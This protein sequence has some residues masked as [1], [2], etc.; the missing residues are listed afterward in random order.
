M[1]RATAGSITAPSASP[2]G[3]HLMPGTT[4]GASAKAGTRRPRPSDA[5]TTTDEVGPIST[6]WRTYFL[7]A[8]AATSNVAASARA[9]GVS[10]S[11][12]YNARRD[13]AEF[14]EAWRGALHE[15]Y[16]HLEMEALAYLRGH[17]PERKLDIAS[18][19]R[20]L[21]A[22]RE[23][24]ASERAKRHGQDEAEV[25]AS[26]ERKLATIRDRLAKDAPGSQTDGGNER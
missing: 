11:R 22:H 13:H 21:A 4:Q 2:R 26:L 14:A 20:L 19:I 12:A 24:V 3:H 5:Q 16:E 6:H 17:D 10:P 23:A 8:L 25:F 1:V 18:A 15:G 9:A 7:E